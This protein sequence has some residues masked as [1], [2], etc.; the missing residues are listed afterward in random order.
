VGTVLVFMKVLLNRV[1]QGMNADEYKRLCSSVF[2]SVFL[3]LKNFELLVCIRSVRI[4]L[5]HLFVSTKGSV[6]RVPFALCIS[7]HSPRRCVTRVCLNNH[8]K[9]RNRTIVVARGKAHGS[10][11]TA[12]NGLVR[13][14][15][16]GGGEVVFRVLEIVFAQ[17][18]LRIG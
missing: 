5:H 17:C 2:L 8:P 11:I 4:K 6:W 15:G 12:E 13:L 1:N 14:D 9:I 16:D 7:Q 18:V 3:C 10:T